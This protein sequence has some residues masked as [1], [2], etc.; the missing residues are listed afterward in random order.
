L[1][2]DYKDQIADA[3]VAASLGQVD[4]LIAPS[5]TRPRVISALDILLC[6]YPLT[7]A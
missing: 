4:E 1:V 6:A 5:A 3:R 7:E 2:E